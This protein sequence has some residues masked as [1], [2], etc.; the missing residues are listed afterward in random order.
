MSMF[1]IDK[2]ICDDYSQNEPN[3]SIIATIWLINYLRISNLQKLFPL[4]DYSEFSVYITSDDI[5]LYNMFSSLPIAMYSRLY[6]I[7]NNHPDADIVITF[8]KDGTD[9]I[10]YQLG[11]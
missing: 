3:S 1:I 7:Y 9:A 6:S 2:Y 4:E 10:L 11:K 8:Y 5:N